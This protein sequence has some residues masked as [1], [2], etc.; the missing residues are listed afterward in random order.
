MSV[1]SDVAHKV[2]AGPSSLNAHNPITPEH[3]SQQSDDI[4]TPTSP[5]LD[6][7][8]TP[9][10]KRKRDDGDEGSDDDF[11]ISPSSAHIGTA[12]ESV[13]FSPSVTRLKARNVRKPR[14]SCTGRPKAVQP[15]YVDV[16][17]GKPAPFG[18]PPVWAEKRQQLCETLPYYRAYQSG[19]YSDN[20]V[21]KGFMIDKEVG[22]RDKFTSE[23]VI[24]S[25]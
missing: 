10:Q 9:Q 11:E 7:I 21:V 20:G 24:C 1:M 15:Y 3:N 17:E 12:E 2:S 25:V 18:K 4:A 22:V 14:V 8:R 5:S 16:Q 13:L 19:A 6:T 23:I